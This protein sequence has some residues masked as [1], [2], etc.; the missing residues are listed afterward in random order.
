MHHL[1]P[2]F[3]TVYTVIIFRI[4][5]NGYWL[6]QDN[7]RPTAVHCPYFPCKCYPFTILVFMG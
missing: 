1:Y 5:Y 4:C 7:G 6:V 2:C 3:G